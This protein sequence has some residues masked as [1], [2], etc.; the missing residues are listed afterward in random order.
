[1]AWTT[2]ASF[3]VVDVQSPAIRGVSI[4]YDQAYASLNG[5]DA[6]PLR[7]WEDE[8]QSALPDARASFGLDPGFIAAKA[9]GRT[10]ADTLPKGITDIKNAQGGVFKS[11]H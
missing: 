1:M 11:V 8:N 10:V 2:T 6:A 7:A 5:Y 9:G 3:A 4:G